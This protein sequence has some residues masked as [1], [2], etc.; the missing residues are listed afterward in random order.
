MDNLYIAAEDLASLHR[1]CFPNRI[2]TVLK[3]ISD[4]ESGASVLLVDFSAV[5]DASGPNTG[6]ELQPGQ[7]I[8][9]TQP[10][11]VWLGEKPESTRHADA[12]DRNS[13]FASKH[14]PDLRYSASVDGW[15]VLVYEI[16]GQS[17]VNF[18]SAD[19]V[20]AQSIRHFCGLVAVSLWREWNDTYSVSAGAKARDTLRGWLG[21]RLN[22][23]DAAP[24]HSHIA[25]Q[26]GS[27]PLFMMT[28]RV[29]VNPLW[30]ATADC[31]ETSAA[32][33]SFG[34]LIHGDLHPGNILVDRTARHRDQYWLIDFALSKEAGLG[35]DQAYLELALLI[36]HLQGAEPQR[37]LNLLEAIDVDDDDSTGSRIPVP[38]V[39]IL[40]C[41]RAIRAANRDWQTAREPKRTDSVTAQL[42]LARIAVGLNWAN[43]QL[44][45]QRRRLATAY[46][47][48]AAT[49]Y[50]Q[51]F[52]P[53]AFSQ[54]LTDEGEEKLS[55]VAAV[56]P[57][58]P[59]VWEQLARFDGT[60]ARYVLVTGRMEPSEQLRSLALV[61]WSVVVDLDPLS[62]ES[63]L[64]SVV[65][66]ALA[67]QRSLNQFGLSP[68]PVDT[69]RGTAWL[70]ANGWPSRHEPVPQ[71]FRRWRQQ[72][73]D[74]VRTLFKSVRRAAAPLPVKVVI[75][76]SEDVDKHYTK[77]LVDWADEG[78]EDSSDITIVGSTAL[79]D[80]P[81]V[82]AHY[83]L[84]PSEFIRA[85]NHVFGSDIQTDEPT[86]PG[87]D[88]PIGVAVDQL[89]SLEEDAFVLHSNVLDNKFPSEGD[90]D[91]FWK[92][93]PPSWSDLHGDVDVRRQIAPRLLKKVTNQLR[94]R[95]NYT[96]EL[97]HAPGAGGTTAAL[98]CAWDLRREFPV[99]VLRQY[100]G[101]TVDRIELLF[102]I[103]Q[104]PVLLVADAA[105][106]PPAS[107]ED[108]YRNIARRN[109][110]CV[111]LYVVR[112]FGSALEDDP[113]DA[114]KSEVGP[115]SLSDSMSD[116]EAESFRLAFSERTKKATRLRLLRDLATAEQW[117][118][119]RNPFF[120]GLTTYEEEFQSVQS[121]VAHHL[122]GATDAVLSVVRNLALVTKYSQTGLTV[123]LLNRFLRLDAASEINR[124]EALGEAIN[125]LIV[126][127]GQVLR[128][129]HPL[130]AQEVLRQLL[131]NNDEWKYGLKDL[132]LQFI[133]DTIEA[134]GP[135]AD[136]TSHL[137]AELFIRREFWTPSVRRRR[138]FSELV[139]DIPPAAG[140]HQ[141]LQ[142]LTEACPEEPHF[143]NHLGRHHIYEMKQ[144]FAAAERHLQKAVELDPRESV[145]HHSLGMVRRFW[146]RSSIAD[147]LRQGQPPSAE[148]MF[149][150]IEVLL[151]S[152]AE[153][154]AITRELA[155]EN[156]HGYI[157]HIQLIIEVL[158]SL[159]RLDADG[160]LPALI[161]KRNR[162]GEWVR[163]S[164][165]AAEELLG[166]VRHLRELEQ[167]SK[168]ELFCLS[169]LAG[170]YGHFDSLISSLE[171]LSK[172]S[173]D[174]D[175]RRVLATA[176]HSKAGRVW[177]NVLPS[178]LRR[179]REL[180]EDNL[181]VIQQ[182]SEMCGDGS[183]HVGGFRSFHI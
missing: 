87:A 66:S 153:E 168:Y 7:Y 72:Y 175:T 118:P 16:A 134:I 117:K 63:G 76:S 131:G 56:T 62:N 173:Q 64:H 147:M 127:R 59:E 178:D 181:G 120:F 38:D 24:L 84:A 2:V 115:L 92:G 112:T 164:V 25:K 180:M 85:V 111:I 96:I 4:G 155:P 104:K 114:S 9:K 18:V 20:D 157:T 65:S 163:G 99:A 75:L 29:L 124:D 121:Y 179:T 45:E 81:A 182:T 57:A 73:A 93:N 160:K 137:F 77:A 151:A 122:A 10:H 14:I 40:G 144:D 52:N 150:D 71:T 37:I 94:A 113:A 116:E 49:R 158:E 126:Q 53:P 8:L 61:P 3:E 106:L 98:R 44:S 123:G 5:H 167:P 58:W 171:T 50:L 97:R 130:I 47:A 108:L 86:L 27:R 15:L 42:L 110:R 88:G 60:K 142:A 109:V 169:G 161:V 74:P 165:A 21:Y 119:Y 19:T 135:E 152:A 140:Q 35:F 148:A 145:H 129:L 39:G 128:L 100:S 6:G 69:E 78:L 41:L 176:Y 105:I 138:N 89:R 183:K 166:Q 33:V 141:V 83:A 51:L 34:G 132:C 136:E 67:R 55:P 133:S 146:I 11:S 139:L 156:S 91:S 95:G 125:R 30:L 17:L 68:I 70:M 107:R 162:V 80:D 36:G 143:W 48:W 22:P 102:R 32:S 177:A 54:L 170:V 43:K 1:K 172:T 149:S 28:D 101:T 26:T 103:S 31:V 13:H 90:T 154:F 174:P 159:L 79:V 46:A 82:K 23:V 12:T